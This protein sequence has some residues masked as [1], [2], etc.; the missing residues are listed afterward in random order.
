MLVNRI[1]VFHNT[2]THGLET[3]LHNLD[4]QPVSFLLDVEGYIPQRLLEAPQLPITLQ[5]R[6]DHCKATKEHWDNLKDYY[7]QHISTIPEPNTP[8]NTSDTMEALLRLT[9]KAMEKHL[10]MRIMSQ[11][12]TL[13]IKTSIFGH[14][15]RYLGRKQKKANDWYHT[16]TVNTYDGTWNPIK[17]DDEHAAL[18]SYNKT[19]FSNLRTKFA[20]FTDLWEHLAVTKNIHTNPKFLRRVTETIHK[21]EEKRITELKHRQ[22]DTCG[23]GM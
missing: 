3:I 4:H 12:T 2:H 17:I 19:V 23:Q 6:V 15:L 9:F 13:K 10:P 18:I 21:L 22:I 20:L 7:H 16:I 11:R 5:K 1:T 8:E 14:I